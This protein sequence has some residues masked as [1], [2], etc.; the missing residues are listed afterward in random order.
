MQLPPNFLVWV[1]NA[2]N[3]CASSSGAGLGE[4]KDSLPFDLT[5]LN[6]MIGTLFANGLAPKPKVKSWF[7]PTSVE[8]LLGNDLIS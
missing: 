3:L 5:E 2:T 8:P 7:Q 6:K 1:V 4:Y